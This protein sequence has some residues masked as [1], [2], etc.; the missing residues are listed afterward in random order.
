M[1][2]KPSAPR[3]P[4]NAARRPNRAQLKAAEVRSAESIGVNNAVT[5]PVAAGPSS[6]AVSRGYILSRDREMAY[7]RNDLR[8]LIITASCLFVLMIVL[9]FLLD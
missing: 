8:R 2:S 4:A 3:K 5:A 6:R 7:V 1:S 9:L